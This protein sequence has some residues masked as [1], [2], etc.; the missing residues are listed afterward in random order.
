MSNWKKDKH[1]APKV[2]PITPGNEVGYGKPP[3]HSQFKKGQS[4]NPAGRQR[5]AANKLPALKVSLQSFCQPQ[6]R[7]TNAFMMSGF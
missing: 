1:L 3:K 6:N 2:Q 5:G 4:G 7:T